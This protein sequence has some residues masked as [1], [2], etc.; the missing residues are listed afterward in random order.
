[1]CRAREALKQ[2]LPDLLR[3][4]SFTACLK[5]DMTT[6]RWLAQLLANAGCESAAQVYG[7]LCGFSLQ[8][9]RRGCNAGMDRP[10]RALR[11]LI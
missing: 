9:S 1:V 4:P 7:F 10:P 5:D 6:R 8:E 11:L 3:D 2:C